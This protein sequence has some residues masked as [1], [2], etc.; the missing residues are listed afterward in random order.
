MSI[1]SMSA[2]DAN[3][4]FGDVIPTKGQWYEIDTAPQ[5]GTHILAIGIYRDELG[6]EDKNP[7][8]HVVSFHYDL[9]E[10]TGGCIYQ[11]WVNATHWMPLPEPPK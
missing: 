8:I 6:N 3:R 7:T 9:W 2:E 10:V 1:L 11:S 5:D 4:I